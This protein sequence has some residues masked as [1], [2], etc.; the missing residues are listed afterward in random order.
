MLDANGSGTDL[1]V[2][3]AFD[4][5]GDL[6]IPIVNASL[7]GASHS[8][9]LEDAVAAHPGTLYAVAAG[10]DGTDNDG[11]DPVYPC[12]LPQGN[13]V[14]VGASDR[15]DARAGF[16]NFGATSVDVFAPG[17]DIVV[18]S[19]GCPGGCLF[20]GTS[21]AAPHVAGILALMRA[22]E[23]SLTTAQLKARLLAG[24]DR[25][26]ALT[27]FSVTGARA[28]AFAAL[29]PT[30][31]PDPGP[32]PGPGPDADPDGDGRVGG[33]DNCPTASNPSQADHDADGL[34]DACDG[35]ADNDGR[36]DVADNCPAVANPD[37]GD[38]D[39]DGLGNLCD[40]TPSGS[41]VDALATTP[42][43]FRRAP[44]LSKPRLS[45]SRVTR[46][47]PAILRLRLDRAATVRLIATRKTRRGY[48]RAGMVTLKR[49]A[50]VSRYKLK[51]RL[52]HSRLRPGRYKLT[53]V[54]LD[55]RLASRTYTLR[56]RVR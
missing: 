24:A 8:Q 49:P 25:V 50:G 55:G 19:N 10:N 40:P 4:L 47:R 46:R 26:G 34:G 54:A 45:R 9:T 18:T 14:C 48:R 23:P 29:D 7:G 43:S 13:V 56:F 1:G 39:G 6:H 17:V 30:V 53:V 27:G 22:R 2:A 31:D 5:A 32:D 37:Q 12:V 44:L 21:A 36:A 20:S 38:G 11:G 51:V 33:A 42:G 41:A 28:N 15:N 16:S 35:D 3:E 52:G